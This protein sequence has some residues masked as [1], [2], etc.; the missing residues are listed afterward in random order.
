M[1]NKF[2]KTTRN[3]I[4]NTFL[5]GADVAHGKNSTE[6]DEMPLKFMLHSSHTA[7]NKSIKL[8]NKMYK[9]IPFAHKLYF[10]FLDNIQYILPL[11]IN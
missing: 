10:I 3:S 6:S 5:Q 7:A 4:W 1:H 9:S 8:I 2:L 11:I